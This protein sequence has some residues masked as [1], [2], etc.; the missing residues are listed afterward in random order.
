LLH[1]MVLALA[2][3][4]PLPANG[5]PHPSPIPIATAPPFATPNVAGPR[6]LPEIV[7][8]PV[9]AIGPGYPEGSQTLPPGDIAGVDEPFVGLS[10]DDAVAMA[11]SRNTDLS[12]AQSNRRIAG[13]QIVAAKGAYDV[14]FM[15]EPMYAVGVTAATSPFQAGPGGGAITQITAGA[16]GAFS[17][18]TGSG[19][20]YRVF[21]SAERIDNNFVYN[22]YDPYYET[23]LGFSFTQP[24]ARNLG[25][26]DRKRAL[27]IA[28]I[29]RDLSNQNALLT[30]SDTLDSVLDAYDDLVAAWRNVA[31]S[32]DA[33]R[34]AKAQEESNARL[35]KHG[36]AA[37]VDIAESDTQVAE[38]QDDVYSAIANVSSLQNGLK[39][40]VLANPA[41]P[42]WTANLVPTSPAR[43]F[44]PEPAIDQIV[45]SALRNRPEVGQLRETIRE[46]DV[47]VA[48]EKNQTKP[49][50]DL[51]LGVTENGFAGQPLNPSSTPL[52]GVIGSEITNL[53]ALIARANAASPGSPLIP[54]DAA[55][56]QT[57]VPPN[58]IGRLG[59][60]Y[61]TALA[62]AFPQYSIS[63][64]LS[65]PL[66]NRTAEANYASEVERR[67]ALQTQEVALI[68][69]VQTEARN[70]VQNYRSAQA[71]IVA[72]TSQ[73]QNAEVVAASELRKFK[74]GAST[75]FLVLQR[76]VALSN[77]RKSELQAQNDLERADV[78]LF[79]VAGTILDSNNVDLT[80]LGTGPEGAVP[81]LTASPAPHSGK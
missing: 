24:L 71:R 2:S 42:L 19:G 30:A 18:N 9:P 37:P 57:S 23:S 39:Q 41:D 44:A 21:T 15:V 47:D 78:E 81:D 56:L 3:A 17:G 31:I 22:G 59:Q 12:L 46:E 25:I 69:R 60:S 53:N 35:V 45:T 73:R 6:S 8:P 65:F 7:T 64:T 68:Q 80:T 27:L 28:S 43:V 5:T 70:A 14:S 76:E 11:L 33:L 20:N 72:T 67:R 13:Y 1:L 61:G 36:A 51:N 58:T 74:A 79:R 34:S 66:R 32:E 29:S 40:L 16:S 62:G 38:F 52:F 26:D 63:A 4:T 77:A 75:T 10:L 54:I 48:Y 49:Q 55:V 50:V